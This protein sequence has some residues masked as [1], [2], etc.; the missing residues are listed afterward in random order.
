M[1]LL[2]FDYDSSSP[3]TDP[4]EPQRGGCC[5]LAAVLERDLVELPITL[6][7][8]HT[9]FVILAPRRGRWIEKADEPRAGVGWRC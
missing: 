6:P 3:D 8:D 9:L 1:P 4:F 2:P 7:Q 5:T